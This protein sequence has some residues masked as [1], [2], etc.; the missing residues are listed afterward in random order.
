MQDLQM[1]N[2]KTELESL[3]KSE[4]KK[5]SW[6]EEKPLPRGNTLIGNDKNAL[7]QVTDD[8]CLLSTG[9]IPQTTIQMN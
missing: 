1:R 3:P 7:V 6:H 8:V 9:I 4:V 2:W 5:K